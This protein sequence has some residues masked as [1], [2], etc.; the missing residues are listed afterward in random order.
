MGKAYLYS[1]TALA[2]VVSCVVRVR[3]SRRVND[4]TLYTLITY[5]MQ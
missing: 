1:Y 4:P 2:W 5:H 3:A